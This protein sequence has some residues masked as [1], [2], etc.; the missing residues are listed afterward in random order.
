MAHHTLD[1]EV[2]HYRANALTQEI[3]ACTRTRVTAPLRA[4]M[5]VTNGFRMAPDRGMIVK[6]K[7]KQMMNTTNGTSSLG[8]ET[9][10]SKHEIMDVM[11]VNIKKVVATVS[12]RASLHGW[13]KKPRG[14]N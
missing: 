10:D 14:K 1:Q 6:M 3:D 13:K 2:A 8:S 5:N 9:W 4:A 7:T 12:V 11:S